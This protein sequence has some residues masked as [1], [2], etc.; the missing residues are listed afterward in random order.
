MNVCICDDDVQELRKTKDLLDEFFKER[1]IPARV[2]CFND[3]SS[4]IKKITYFN[5]ECNYDF[6]FLD[7]VMPV[8]GIDVAA[9][10][11]KRNKDA[12]IIFVTTSREYAIDAF[13]VKAYNYILK[14]IQKDELTNLMDE[15]LKEINVTPKKS[16]SFHSSAYSVISIDI[17][18]VNFIESNNRRMIIHLISFEEVASPTLRNKFIESIPFDY[19]KYFFI[20]CHSSFI[21]NLNQI[22][23]IEKGYFTMKN[24][25]NVPISKQYFKDVKQKYIEYLAGNNYDL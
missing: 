4:L 15:A 24:G 18:S 9:E 16:F 7:I 22:R 14:P 17:D 10:I 20:V 5:E 11:K 2:D 12:V 1:R 21:V 23:S 3:P 13:K 6:Y 25:E 19:E 8:L